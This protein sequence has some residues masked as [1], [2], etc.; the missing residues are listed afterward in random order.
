M[1]SYGQRALTYWGLPKDDESLSFPLDSELAPIQQLL[2]KHRMSMDTAFE[3]RLTRYAS[4]FPSQWPPPS[5]RNAAGTF[6]HGKTCRL[7]DFELKTLQIRSYKDDAKTHYIHQVVFTIPPV[8]S[9]TSSDT[10]DFD[11]CAIVHIDQVR[12]WLPSAQVAPRSNNEYHL[13]I[14]IDQ[15]GR[16][17]IVRGDDDRVYTFVHDPISLSFSYDPTLVRRQDDLPKGRICEEQ[18][19]PSF[20]GGIITDTVVAPIGPFCDWRLTLSSLHNPGLN[21]D[22]V[23]NTQIEFWG[24]NEQ[25]LHTN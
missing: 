15:L 9:N 13:V 10:S 4:K 2:L 16:E 19:I 8:T 23:Q 22:A 7:I 12:V 11:G 25:F 6:A 24:T 21:L 18:Q 20:N 14:G 17:S 1:L 5:G 3:S